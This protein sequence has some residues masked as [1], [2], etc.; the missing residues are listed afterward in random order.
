MLSAV[1]GVVG[2]LLGT[3]IGTV[4]GWFLNGLTLK[5]KLHIYPNWEN[6]FAS[7]FKGFIEITRNNV[8][9][10]HYKLS[11]DIHND[12]GISQIMRKIE[13]VFFHDNQELLRDTPYDLTNLKDYGSRQIKEKAMPL[14]IPAKTI[15]NIFFYGSVEDTNVSRSMIKQF[16]KVYI[17][18]RDNKDKE[19]LVMLSDSFCIDS[20]E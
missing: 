1:I 4:L 12:S 18:Y 14:T 15:R 17:S 20:K 13:I 3:V 16:N 9:I 8:E 5:G 6:R 2:T 19:H 11:L 7:D 10:F